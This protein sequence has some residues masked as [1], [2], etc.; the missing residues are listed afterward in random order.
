M[1]VLLLADIN[2]SHTQNW[3]SS[4]VAN[5][6]EIQVFSLNPLKNL[7]INLPKVKVTSYFKTAND[8][9]I[10]SRKTEETN[11]RI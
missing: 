11:Q 7:N 9:C 8:V 6:F 4:L 2:T 10:C 1:K 3:A 5:N